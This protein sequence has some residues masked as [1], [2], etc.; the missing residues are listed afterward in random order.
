MATSWYPT[1]GWYSN[2][3][4]HC[5][6]SELTKYEKSYMFKHK[7]GKPVFCSKI[8]TNKTKMHSDRSS[9]GYPRTTISCITFRKVFEL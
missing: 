2:I 1:A 9:L 6:H 3:G 4:N 5:K 7:H 8:T